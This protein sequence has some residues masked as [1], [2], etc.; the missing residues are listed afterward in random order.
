MS[1]VHHQ[2]ANVRLHFIL[3]FQILNTLFWGEDELHMTV[4]LCKKDLQAVPAHLM[5]NCV[6]SDH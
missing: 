6:K 4:M 3:F 5:D 2:K 1:E